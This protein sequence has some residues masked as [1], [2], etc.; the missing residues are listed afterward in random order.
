MARKQHEL[1]TQLTLYAAIMMAILI[2]GFFVS[3]LILTH[4]GLDF[5]LIL[6]LISQLAYWEWLDFFVL[7]VFII[8]VV[9]FSFMI[10]VRLKP[11]LEINEGMKQLA[12]GKFGLECKEG[13]G[14]IIEIRE[15]QHSFNLLSRELEKKT[16]LSNDF[17]DNFSHEFKTPIVSIAGFAKILEE[18][19]LSADKEKQYLRIIAEESTRLSDLS[20]NMLLLSRIEN[21]VILP[22]RKACDVSEIARRELLLLQPQWEARHLELDL[23]LDD[24]LIVS[25][26]EGLLKEAI[27]NLLTNALKFAPDYSV[28]AVGTVGN[29]CYVTNEGSLTEDEQEHVFDKFYQSDASHTSQGNGIGLSIVSRVMQLH[30]GSILLDCSR[31]GYVKFSLV[32]PEQ[33]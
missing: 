20:Q 5:S 26:N 23:G 12:T 1:V 15:L 2:I 13:T 22:E 33:K 27:L 31:E 4:G 29:S 3:L 17:I 8:V 25:G 16:V 19:D 24:E 28:L 18:G 32:F 30:G 9:L 6:N 21:T 14:N 11:L 7:L 10:R